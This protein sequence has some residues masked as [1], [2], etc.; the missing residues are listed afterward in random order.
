MST[1]LS[2]IHQIPVLIVCDRVF[3]T[4]TGASSIALFP[5]PLLESTR[6]PSREKYG[7]AL[8]TQNS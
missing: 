3:N 2:G 7:P 4:F 8:I 5:N 6:A 1:H